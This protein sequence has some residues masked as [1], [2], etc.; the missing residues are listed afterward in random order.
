MKKRRLS[1]LLKLRRPL[2]RSDRTLRARRNHQ[3]LNSGPG[4]FGDLEGAEA[5]IVDPEA[6]GV[7]ARNPFGLLA[8][9]FVNEVKRSTVPPIFT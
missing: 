9:A 1:D 7:N 5:D 6:A 3:I 4:Q 2:N 8:E